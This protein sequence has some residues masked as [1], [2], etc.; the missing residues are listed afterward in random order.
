[1]DIVWLDRALDDIEAVVAYIER[2]NPPASRNMLSLI[3]RG[4]EQ[5]ARF[6][7]IGRP[8]RVVGTREMVI[9]GTPFIIP[10]RVKSD[11]VEILAV[12]H[13]ARQWPLSY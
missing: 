4:V 9:L 11:R 10:Y 13:G 6:P 3:R 7:D 1:M 2:E 8:G 12:M 5:L